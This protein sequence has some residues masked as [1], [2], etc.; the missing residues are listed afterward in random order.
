MDFVPR[1]LRKFLVPQNYKKYSAEDQAVWRFIMN[2]IFKNLSLNDQPK[3][4]ESLMK[5]GIDPNQI[6]KIKDIDKNLKPFGWR[7]VCISGFIPPRAFMEFQQNK[8]LPIA[9]ELRT[10]EHIFY[11]PA[12]DIV[13]EA[14][15][16]IPFLDHP[17]F[18]KFL[19]TYAETVLKAVSSKED[20]EKYRAIRDLSDL[21]ENPNSSPLQ[22][23]KQEKKLQ[24]IIQNISYTSES[25]Y[26]SRL[27]W[28]TSEYGLMEDLKKPKVY[29]AGLISSI[30]ELLHLEKV[31]KL[32]LSPRCIEYPFDITDFQPQLFVGKNFDHLLEVLENLS[33]K[34]AF[35]RGGVY[36]VEQALA[37]QTVNTIVLDSGLQMSGVL[38]KSFMNKRQIHFLKFQGPVQL[39]YKNKELEGHGVSYHRE[40]YS[41]PLNLLKTCFDGNNLVSSGKK[42]SQASV[43]SRVSASNGKPFFLVNRQELLR[44]GFK[45]GKR[46]KLKFSEGI[47]ME[48]E[49]VSSLKKE[50]KL[51]LMQFKDCLMK[52]KENQL[53][54]HPSWGPFDMAVGSKVVSVFSGP[55]DRN[56]Y[57]SENDFE[58][59]K[60]PVKNF[61]KKEKKRHL[62]YEKIHKLKKLN[63]KMI[64]DLLKEIKKQDNNWLLL[65]EL[66][67]KIKDYS[68]KLEPKLK[69]QFQAELESLKKVKRQGY[70]PFKIGQEFYTD[71]I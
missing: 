65:L 1:H 20:M 3:T 53:L 14:V 46:M 45:K 69:K 49:F 2:G 61:T 56:S 6:P 22:I 42:V 40:G 30:G 17:V 9:S 44:A 63:S 8:I 58:P 21:K 59:S 48:A 67:K 50:G 15:G 70:T 4:L 29:G 13:H 66:F 11:T 18:S 33:K 5:K 10:L 51:L 55:A 31:K 37:S 32:K 16:H 52:D 19:S 60:V 36:G 35:H 23:K 7:A 39:S 26:L 68:F 54:Y 34:L 25:A 62:L 64:S 43:F 47:Q 57:P 38:E 71:L 12:P 27:I 41:T 24:Q 28:W